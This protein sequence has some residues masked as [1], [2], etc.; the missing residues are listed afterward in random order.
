MVEAVQALEWY[1]GVAVYATYEDD[2]G[3]TYT[4]YS[5]IVKFRGGKIKELASEAQ[6]LKAKSNLG[7]RFDDRTFD[8]FDVAIQP[9]AYSMAADFADR[10]DLFT[11]EK[12]SLI[13]M[14]EQGTGKT[15]LAAAIA[16]TLIG[17]GI[18]VLFATY[19]DHL[20]TL[21]EEFKKTGDYMSKLGSTPLLVIDDL[22][23]EVQGEWANSMLF[24]IVNHRYEHKLPTVITTNLCDKELQD[25]Y[26]KSI[27][28]RLI[29]MA[30]A[31]TMNNGD[32]RLLKGIKK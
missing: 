27:V 28:S 20:A 7:A 26:G 14:G 13:L 30:Y 32:Y 6:R 23:K 5:R 31:I 1:N 24:T 18:P 16:N 17:R 3:I 11:A 9:R 19:T 29:E 10:E 8:N 2:C 25:K 21:K 15:H 12:N 4:D 22:G